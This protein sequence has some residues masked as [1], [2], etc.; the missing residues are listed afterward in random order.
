M[1]S[2]SLASSC[3][4]D[5]MMGKEECTSPSGDYELKIPVSKTQ[6]CDETK[7]RDTNCKELDV[8]AVKPF[9]E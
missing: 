2:H 3:M 4:E 5:L 8:S 1:C 7:M 6:S 9:V